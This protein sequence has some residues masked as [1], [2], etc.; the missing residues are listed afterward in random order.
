MELQNLKSEFAKLS[1]DFKNVVIF[2]K[3]NTQGNQNEI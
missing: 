1:N 2:I 3:Q